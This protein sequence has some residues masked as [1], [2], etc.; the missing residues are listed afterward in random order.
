MKRKK[1][2]KNGVTPK[3]IIREFF[4]TSKPVQVYLKTSDSERKESI[5]NKDKHLTV[6]QKPYVQIAKVAFSSITQQK[7]GISSTI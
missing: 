1:D 7:D 2:Y 4:L 3:N 5:I 6:Q